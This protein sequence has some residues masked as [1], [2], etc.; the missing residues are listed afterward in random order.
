MIKITLLSASRT[1]HLAR[2]DEDKSWLATPVVMA[3]RIGSGPPG[4]TCLT[5][6]HLDLAESRWSNRGRAAMC[7]ERQRL[8]HGKKVQ[9]VPVRSAACSRH[10]KRPDTAAAI[11][12]AEQ[13]L[14]ERI[15]AKQQKIADLQAA[16]KRLTGEIRELERLREDVGD[17]VNWPNFEP[18]GP[19]EGT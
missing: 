5:C 17:D 4:E 15:A 12:T 8:A 18:V 6:I 13:R 1:S 10:A 7:L 9:E 19:D 11:A 14:D 3:G 2:S 16:G